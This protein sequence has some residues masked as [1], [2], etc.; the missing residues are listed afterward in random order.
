MQEHAK[1]L[2]TANVFIFNKVTVADILQ[3]KTQ[4]LQ[5]IDNGESFFTT[6][7]RLDSHTFGLMKKWILLQCIY[8]PFLG[9][10]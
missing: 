10:N 7:M 6:P 2:H 3:K 1:Y 5:S 9:T 4:F 8:I